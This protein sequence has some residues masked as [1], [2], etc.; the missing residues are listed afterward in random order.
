[1]CGGVGRRVCACVWLSLV[2]S[3]PRYPECGERVQTPCERA[4]VERGVDE[5]GS[6]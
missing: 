3:E 5:E 6:L 4:R 1:M 2:C